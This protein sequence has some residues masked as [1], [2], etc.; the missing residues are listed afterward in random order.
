MM[1]YLII[2]HLVCESPVDENFPLYNISFVSTFKKGQCFYIFIEGSVLL[3][4]KINPTKVRCCFE[5]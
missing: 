1:E 2:K 5:V 4:A 3:L